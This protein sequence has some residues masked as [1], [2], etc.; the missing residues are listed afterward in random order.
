MESIQKITSAGALIEFGVSPVKKTEASQF[1][2]GS[3]P[4]GKD[5]QGT[6]RAARGTPVNFGKVAESVNKFVHS[7]GT[8]LQCKYDERSS[9]PV[10]VVLDPETGEVIRQIPPKEMLNLIVKLNDINGIIFRGRG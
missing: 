1:S 3:G 8:K 9:R 6:G 10:I 5:L 7:L 2:S 4:A